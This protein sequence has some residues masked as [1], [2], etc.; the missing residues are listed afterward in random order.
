[1]RWSFVNLSGGERPTSCPVAERARVLGQYLG[2]QIGLQ[3]LGFAG[4]PRSCL[5][6]P[7][8]RTAI[9]LLEWQPAMP[10]TAVYPG[11]VRRRV[12]RAPFCQIQNY[13]QPTKEFHVLG[14]PEGG[15]QTTPVVRGEGKAAPLLRL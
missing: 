9:L 1:M 8:L 10:G 6:P 3:I 2:Q 5:V 11:E 13:L 14:L 7:M 15:G 12:H 4:S